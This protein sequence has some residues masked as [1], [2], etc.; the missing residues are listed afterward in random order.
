[1]WLFVCMERKVGVKTGKVGSCKMK[2][3]LF[4]GIWGGG[5]GRGATL[6]DG[7]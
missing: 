6:P 1:M 4:G 7:F 5:G 3:H 2:D